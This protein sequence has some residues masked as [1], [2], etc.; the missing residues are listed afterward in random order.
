MDKFWDKVVDHI[1]SMN[2][3]HGVEGLWGAHAQMQQSIARMTES[4]EELTAVQEENALQKKHIAQQDARALHMETQHAKYAEGM[5]KSFSSLQDEMQVF[6]L[7][8]LDN[9]AEQ[10]AATKQSSD[11]H[12]RRIAEHNAVHKEYVQELTQ[13]FDA[14]LAEQI[15][16]SEVTE[17]NTRAEQDAVHKQHVQELTQYFDVKLA[18]QIKRSEVTE[19]NTRAELQL[20]SQELFDVKQGTCLPPLVST[21]ADLDIWNDEATFPVCS[22][23]SINAFLDGQADM[24]MSSDHSCSLLT[25]TAENAYDDEIARGLAEAA[26]GQ[27]RATEDASPSG[28]CSFDLQALVYSHAGT[29]R[30]TN[31]AAKHLPEQQAGAQARTQQPTAALTAP[32]WNP[33][34]RELCCC[35]TLAKLTYPQLIQRCSDLRVPSHVHAAA[36]FKFKVGDRVSA[37]YKKCHYKWPG[38]I[39][40]RHAAEDGTATYSVSFD[41]GDVATGI[42]EKFMDR[43]SPATPKL[44][45]AIMAPVILRDLLRTYPSLE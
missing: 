6:V 45:V 33:P 9:A 16:R 32:A 14:K 40:N 35:V 8:M 37:K 39:F 13:S 43:E 27:K 34:P 4:A 23:E 19:T 20:V 17:T 2:Q 38:E 12:E 29:V 3:K 15:K 1:E 26:F 22:V 44:P 5:A 7:H 41:D 25:T 31:K 11:M 10:L 30:D 24:P 42:K 28:L 18:E 36:T 21:A